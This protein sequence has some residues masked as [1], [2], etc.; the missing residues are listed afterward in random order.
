MRFRHHYILKL[1]GLVD[2]DGKSSFTPHAFGIS[3]AACGSQRE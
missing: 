3:L 1:A 2:A